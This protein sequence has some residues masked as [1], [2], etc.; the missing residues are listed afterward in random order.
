MP[1]FGFQWSNQEEVFDAAQLWASV[2]SK[3][4]LESSKL[5]LHALP[6]STQA[7][8]VGKGTDAGLLHSQ[9]IQTHCCL[10]VIFADHNR[11]PVC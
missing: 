8:L 7:D 3:E 11:A 9:G 10:S 6:N 2:C 5:E 1:T 4:I